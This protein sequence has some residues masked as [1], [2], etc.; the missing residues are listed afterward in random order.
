MIRRN[1]D[2]Q[3][4]GRPE[5]LEC[6]VCLSPMR[7]VFRATILRDRTGCYDSCSACGFLRVRS[8]DW[9]DSAYSSAICAAD[10]GLVA[11]N[12]RLADRLA[13]LLPLLGPPGPVLDYGGGTGLLVRLMRDRGFDFRWSDRHA[14]NEHARGFEHDAERDPPCVAVTAFEVLEHVERPV[15]FVAEALVA[16]RSDT[17]V[18]TTE[19][20]AGEPPRDWWYYAREEGQHVSFFRRDTLAALGARLG[21]RLLS[22]GGVHV[23]TRGGLSQAALARSGTRWARLAARLRDRRRGSLVAADHDAILARLHREH[24]A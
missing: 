3:G 1:G 7:E 15:E 5:T 14:R 9:L 13:A 11:R 19:L 21:L 2:P 4:V 16:G 12:L 6:P 17:L 24:R 20:F 18:F 10:T 8:P 22:D 23:L